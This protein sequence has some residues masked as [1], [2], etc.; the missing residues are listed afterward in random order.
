MRNFCAAIMGTISFF[1]WICTTDII[2]LWMFRFK[3]GYT[4]ILRASTMHLLARHQKE[5]K[6]TIV[7]CISRPHHLPNLAIFSLNFKNAFLLE[8][9]VFW[10]QH[11][12]MHENDMNTYTTKAPFPANQ[13]ASSLRV[14]ASNWNKLSSNKF[15]VCL[16]GE[17]NI[18]VK[19]CG[20][21]T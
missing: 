17:Y 15:L 19:L 3:L 11:A 16:H 9:F 2:E 14:L 5:I 12:C 6:V 20:N 18:L 8:F 7:K 13:L 4:D 10:R 21:T 1:R